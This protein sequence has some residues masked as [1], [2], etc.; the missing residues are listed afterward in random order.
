MRAREAPADIARRRSNEA[1]PLTQGKGKDAWPDLSLR[2][3][4]MTTLAATICQN[5]GSDLMPHGM[6]LLPT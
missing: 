2:A 3:A 5:R 4:V 1:P 6:V